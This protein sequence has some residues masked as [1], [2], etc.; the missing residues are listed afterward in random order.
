MSLDKAILGFL[1][2]KPFTGYDLK[3]VFDSSVHHFWPAD[4]SQIYRTMSRLEDQ[5]YLTSERIPQE[6]RP[7]Q[8]LYH[9]TKAGKEALYTWLK[10][11]PPME[12]IRYP[13]LIQVF[14][15]GLLEDDDIL[16]VFEKKAE[17]LRGL[18]ESLQVLEQEVR[19]HTLEFPK[20]D[21]YFWLLTLEHG[22]WIERAE[23]EWI[24]KVIG[25]LKNN[26]HK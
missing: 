4:Q 17:G 13:F 5:G 15:A 26:E 7:P 10:G 8:K 11:P 14:F 23:L 25:R 16:A 24:E 3:K 19:E 2:Y 18:L 6:D 20:K 9:L 22:K 21:R 12:K 1:S